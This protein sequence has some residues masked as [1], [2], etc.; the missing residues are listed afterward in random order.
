MGT[1]DNA[2][3]TSIQ[4]CVGHREPMRQVDAARAIAGFGIEGDVHAASEGPRTARQVLLMDSETLE[5]FGLTHSQVRENITTGGFAPGSVAVGQR[6]ALG[7]A[8]VLEVTGDCA[9]CGRMDEIRPGLRERLEGRRGLLATV[10]EGGTMN[11]GDPI[12]AVEP[13]PAG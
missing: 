9:P 12:R 5:E 2:R 13:E 7:D 4:L 11:V 8:V 3:I 6:L 10:I 1:S